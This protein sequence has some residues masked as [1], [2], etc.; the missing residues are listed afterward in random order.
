MFS[1]NML[2]RLQHR[3]SDRCQW[4]QKI[5]VSAV[6]IPLLP[7]SAT[8]LH[9]QGLGGW[10]ETPQRQQKATAVGSTNPRLHCMPKAQ[11]AS[12]LFSGKWT[13]SWN[14]QPRCLWKILNIQISIPRLFSP[15]LSFH[16]L[17]TGTVA[18]CPPDDLP[19]SLMMSIRISI[20]INVPV[21]PIP[22]LWAE[23][24]KVMTLEPFVGVLYSKP[25]INFNRTSVCSWE[26]F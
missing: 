23:G 16:V 5:K 3:P 13:E 12:F 20:T 9:Q 7:N 11:I 26:Y 1:P 21:R 2:W 25:A 17:K 19:F 4:S 24:Q 22:A 18:S 14:L 6:R 15:V 8:P 10:V